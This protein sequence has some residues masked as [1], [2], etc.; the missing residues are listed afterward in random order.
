MPTDA[1][2]DIVN[3]LFS[4]QKDLSDYVATGMND[5]A[6]AAI[7]AMKKEVGAQAFKPEEPEEETPTEEEPN[8]ETDQGGD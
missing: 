2:R 7:D 4:G 8:D 3:A 5:A 6:V 1:A